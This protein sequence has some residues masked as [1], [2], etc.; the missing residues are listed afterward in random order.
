MLRCTVWTSPRSRRMTEKIW[1][2]QLLPLWFLGT[3]FNLSM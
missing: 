1:R 2:L 3:Q